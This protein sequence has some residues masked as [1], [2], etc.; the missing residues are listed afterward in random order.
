M[1]GCCSGGQQYPINKLEWEISM[2]VQPKNN[3]PKKIRI[4][5]DFQRLNKLTVTD[6]FPT[7]FADEIINEFVVHEFY[8]FTN[9]FS[10]YNQVPIAKED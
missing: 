8:S 6:P 5:V 4:C 2:F 9:G 10:D 7:L 3:D 1:V